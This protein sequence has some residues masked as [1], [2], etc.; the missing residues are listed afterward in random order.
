MEGYRGSTKEEEEETKGGKE[1]RDGACEGSTLCDIPRC[2]WKGGVAKGV[3]KKRKKKVVE[4]GGVRGGGAGKRRSRM[5]PW[6]GT[7]GAPRLLG[8]TPDSQLLPEG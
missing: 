1:E 3:R 4:Q 6:P 7:Y 8:P 2:S 5:T